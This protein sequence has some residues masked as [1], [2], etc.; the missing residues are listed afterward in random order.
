MEL[1]DILV[2]AFTD[3][4]DT[5]VYSLNVT[6][7]AILMEIILP[8]EEPDIIQMASSNPNKDTI[9]LPST[10]P[11][12]RKRI[13][14]TFVSQCKTNEPEFHK[15][16][17]HRF[18]E[19]KFMVAVKHFNL[20]KQWDCFLSEEYRAELLQWLKYSG[21]SYEI[22]NKIYLENQFNEFPKS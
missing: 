6:T 19:K 17:S 11:A 14:K 1:M 12:E 18:S 8:S 15:A 2:E 3:G 16:C 9:V 10:T 22:L 21:L 4:R 13:M 7:G 5:H 20:Q